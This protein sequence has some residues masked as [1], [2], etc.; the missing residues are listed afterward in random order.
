MYDSS[1]NLCYLLYDRQSSR[2]FLPNCFFNTVVINLDMCPSS[3]S[4]ICE[5][6]QSC[7]RTGVEADLKS[8]L[9]IAC[10]STPHS[11]II[12]LDFPTLI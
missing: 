12:L 9:F 2:D 10:I 7:N 3:L 6:S 5:V 11:A 8:N 4:Y 1:S